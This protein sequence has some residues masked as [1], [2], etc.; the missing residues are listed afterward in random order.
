[1]F[2]GWAFVIITAFIFYFLL[3]RELA[4]VKQTETELRESEEKF[5]TLADTSPLAIY[6]SSGADQVAEYINPSFVKLFGYTID[7]VPTVEK[8]W[9]LAYP[10]EDYRNFIADEWQKKVE[11]AIETNSEIEPIE[12]IVTCKDGSTK[13]VSWG[14]SAVG[15]QNWALGLDLTDRKKAEQAL[16]YER[17]LSIDIINTQSTG[18]YRI[19]V[20]AKESWKKDAWR[21]AK[22]SPVVVELASEPFCKILNTTKKAFKD[23]PGLMLDLIYHDDREGFVKKNEDAVLLEKFYWEGRLFIDGVI[24]W[25]R[26]ESFP[27]PLENGDILWTGTLIDINERKQ[28]EVEREK[29]IAQLQNKTEEQERFIY[30]ASHDLKSPLVTI[31]GFAEIVERDLLSGNQ[32]RAKE[33]LNE[34]SSAAQHMWQLLDD[35]LEI[36]RVGVLKNK[37]EVVNLGALITE[38]AENLSGVINEFNSTLEVEPELPDVMVDKQRFLQVF[39]NLIV[40]AIR[41]SKEAKGG[42]V[43]KVGVI[44]GEGELTCYVKDNGIGIDAEYLDKIFGLFERLETGTS[45]TGVGL[46]IVKRIVETH[47][48]RIWAESKGLGHGTTLF[49]T[50]SE[51]K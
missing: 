42:S 29:L 34:I 16:Q 15:G 37:K 21:N 9:P 26:F 8:W 33:S 46:A 23:N 50:L 22:D 38:S 40:N 4:L 6:M 45:G 5:R 49:F 36:S 7:E 41:Y 30:T 43:A 44:R 11:R 18:I 19:R 39:E 51:A 27:R 2:K 31:S 13:N 17:D 48:G 3:Y 32:E 25:V 24:K 35:L 10:D 1:M 12:T 47:G 28:M 20:S 14:F